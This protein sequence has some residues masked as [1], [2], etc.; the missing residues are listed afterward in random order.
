[1]SHILEMLKQLVETSNQDKQVAKKICK[2]D[3]AIARCN[4]ELKR[5]ID[6]EENV[7]KHIAQLRDNTDKLEEKYKL[8]KVKGSFTEQSLIERSGNLTNWKMN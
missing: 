8:S 5:L 7:I 1:M 4:I 6:K 3:Q 2:D